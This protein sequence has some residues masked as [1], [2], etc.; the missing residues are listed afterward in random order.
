CPITLVTRTADGAIVGRREIL[1]LPPVQAATD[2]TPFVSSAIF[3]VPAQPAPGEATRL[4]V[5]L[6]N[7][8]A[9]AKD[10]TVKFGLGATLSTA[11]V[12]D[13]WMQR[14][15]TLPA[16]SASE[17][18]TDPVTW[19]GDRSV[20]VELHQSGY[21]PQT[22][23]R[24]VGALAWPEVSTFTLEVRNPGDAPVNASIALNA[25]GLPGWQVTGP[26]A[27]TLGAHEAQTI[28]VHLAA[29][30]VSAGTP[31]AAFAG[32]A[33]GVQVWVHA[34]DGALIGGAWVQVWHRVGEHAVFLPL[35]ARP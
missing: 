7:R 20:V 10:V 32:D 23:V 24:N 9:T 30:D 3:T 8:A 14:Q 18:C 27:L 4:C 22:V 12:V 29:P 11:P 25:V 31:A 28:D 34:Q 1:D 35:A 17:V 5:A 16:S 2:Q 19:A 15:V 21:Q 6:Q 26:A 13:T 33:G